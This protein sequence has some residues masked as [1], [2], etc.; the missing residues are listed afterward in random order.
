MEV[1]TEQEPP[2][3]GMVLV[4]YTRDGYIV[5]CWHQPDTVPDRKA[6]GAIIR[7]E[8]F[9]REKDGEQTDD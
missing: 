9:R 8:V 4:K 6:L 2:E 3:P 5:R 1:L 7:S